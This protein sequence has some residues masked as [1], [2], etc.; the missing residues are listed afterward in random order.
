MAYG[1]KELEERSLEQCATLFIVWKIKLMSSRGNLSQRCCRRGDIAE[2]S[3]VV[4]KAS[5]TT[6]LRPEL[7]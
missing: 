4:D 1:V 3:L 5:Q 7:K 2:R 6:K